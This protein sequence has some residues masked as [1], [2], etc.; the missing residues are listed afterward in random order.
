MI[1]D[2]LY[3]IVA[4]HR[5]QQERINTIRNK[6]ER[7]E[8]SHSERAEL[9]IGDEISSDQL[10]DGEIG[11]DEEEFWAHADVAPL[12][13]DPKGKAKTTSGGK[14]GHYKEANCYRMDDL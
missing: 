1:N 2:L 6:Q 13:S 7:Q 4:E 9:E 3:D 12:D 11:E 10:A 5:A 8:P 14:T